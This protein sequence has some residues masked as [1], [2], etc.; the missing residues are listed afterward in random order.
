MRRLIRRGA[1]GRP[2][3]AGGSLRPVVV[4]PCVGRAFRSISL[5]CP[6][7]ARARALYP[8][9]WLEGSGRRMTKRRGD[10]D[11][12]LIGGFRGCSGRG[13][14]AARRRRAEQAHG[15]CP[16]PRS[17][18]QHYR[19]PRRDHRPRAKPHQFHRHRRG[20]RARACRRCS[21]RRGSSLP[22]SM[23][24]KKSLVDLEPWLH[25]PAFE[26]V[27]VLARGATKRLQAASAPPTTSPWSNG[28]TEGQI[29]RAWRG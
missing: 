15:G 18:A 9:Q 6:P 19:A 3:R 12:S 27:A 23:I 25:G 29:T 17:S 21:K 4:V 10:G 14:V 13:R 26:L 28:Q 24:R 20:D 16:A 1:P 5:Q 8:C 2:G 22:S 11:A 7:G